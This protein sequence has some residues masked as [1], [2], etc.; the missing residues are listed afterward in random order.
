VIRHLIGGDDPIGDVLATVTL[1]PTGGELTC[2]IGE[3][4]R[5]TMDRRVIG[6][7]AVTVR[8]IGRIERIKVQLADRCDHK[9]RR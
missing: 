3:V 6:R 1:D 5:L 7:A 2:R 4:K 8:A 9:P